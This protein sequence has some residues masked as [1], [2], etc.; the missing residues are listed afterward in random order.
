M[1]CNQCMCALRS[2][3]PPEFIEPSM[4]GPEIAGPTDGW[5]FETTAGAFV[6]DYAK[7]DACAALQGR[8]LGKCGEM[9]V[10]KTTRGCLT[11]QPAPG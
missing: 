1:K 5:A 9:L 11:S 6:S 2:W 8:T 3:G 4:R 7:K 10:Q